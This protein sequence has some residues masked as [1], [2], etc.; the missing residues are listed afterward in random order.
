M[1]RGKEQRGHFVTYWAYLVLQPPT[2]RL[3]KGG[4]GI[5]PSV[6]VQS[7]VSFEI[8]LAPWGLGR[9]KQFSFYCRRRLHGCALPSFDARE[10]C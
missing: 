10:S 9:S 3:G 6:C 5:N 8:L 4:G 7:Q 1:K 2:Q